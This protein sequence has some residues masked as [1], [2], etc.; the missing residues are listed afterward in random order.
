M[1]D[2]ASL[3]PCN[4]EEANSCMLLHVSHAADYGHRKLLIWTVD[5]D[6]VVL[7]LSVA[8]CLGTEYE[9]WLAFGTSKHFWY[10]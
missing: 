9:L 3:S 6:V 4:H 5:T 8:Q 7:A 2:L 10:I 1:D